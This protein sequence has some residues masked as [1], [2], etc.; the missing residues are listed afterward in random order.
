[1]GRPVQGMLCILAL[2]VVTIPV[3]VVQLLTW[4]LLPRRWFRY[5]SS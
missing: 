2:L 1:M 3:N 4:L 5:V